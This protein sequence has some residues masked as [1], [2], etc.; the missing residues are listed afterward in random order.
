MANVMQTLSD[1]ATLAKAGLKAEEIKEIIALTKDDGNK[2]EAAPEITPKEAVQPEAQKETEATK[3]E[4]AINYKSMFE[5]ASKQIETLKADL[6]KAQ[7]NNVSKDISGNIQAPTGQDAINE[8]F[9]K[10]IN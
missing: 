3:P 1:L 9:S 7:Q 4:D 10:I 8:I 5:D 2:T 6:A